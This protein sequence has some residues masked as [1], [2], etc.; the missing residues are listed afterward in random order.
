ML[1]RRQAIYLACAMTLGLAGISGCGAAV[2]Q[3]STQTSFG[4]TTRPS[5]DNANLNW[6]VPTIQGVDED[7]QSFSSEQLKGDVYILDVFY[8]SCPTVCSPI[9]SNMAYLQRQLKKA[10]SDIQ[11][12]SLSVD[13]Q[14]ETPTIL[15]KFGEQ[16]GA[17]FTNWHFLTGY[18]D[19]WI[20]SFSLSA[21]KEP[22]TKDS[23]N[24]PTYSHTVNWYLVNQSG[25]IVNFFN[26]LQPPYAKIIQAVQSLES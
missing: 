7:G 3:N 11:F 15:K 19:A 6:P 2:S 20:Q 16:R 5:N 25:K 12:L 13:P 17:D 18:S 14:F 22:I 8:S 23:S 26:G 4:A 9:A 24:P 21:L 1:K 10:G